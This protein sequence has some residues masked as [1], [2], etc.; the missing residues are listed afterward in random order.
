MKYI[1][2]NNKNAY[3]I[4]ANDMANAKNKAIN[5]CNHSHEII[6]RQI[7]DVIRFDND[8]HNKL[9]KDLNTYVQHSANLT[10]DLQDLANEI[11]SL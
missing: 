1:I 10:K 7:N 5:I 6:V 3:V 11:D 9:I 2:I 8:Y 4:E